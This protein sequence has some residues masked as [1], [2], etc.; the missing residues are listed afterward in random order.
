MGLWSGCIASDRTDLTET[1]QFLALLE[2][3]GIRMVNIT[4]GSPYYNPHIQRPLVS[5]VGW[6]STAGGPALGCGAADGCNATVEGYVSQP[7]LRG[8]RLQL[9]SGFFAVC[10]A[11]CGAGWM[12]GLRRPRPHG[13]FVPGDFV[14]CFGGEATSTQAGVQNF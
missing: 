6:I 7:H 9:S 1:V 13:A 3:L 5:A 2:E 8:L 12:D 10:C 4:R 14:G 11:S